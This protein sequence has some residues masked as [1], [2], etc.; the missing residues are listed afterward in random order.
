MARNDGIDRTSVRNLAV[1]D[2][3]VGNTQQHNEREKDSYRNPDILPHRTEWNV[4]FKKPTASYT[5]LFAQMEAAGTISTRGLKPD[6]THYCELIFDV[7]SAYFDNHGGYEFAKQFYAD[8]YKAAVQ[9]AGGEQYILSAVMHADEINRAMT[10]ALGREVY[11]YHLHVVY[12]PVVEKQILW[13]KRCKDKALVGTVKE[14]VMQV[15][16]SK[17]WASKPLLDDAGKPVLQK[18]G[19]PVLKKSYSVLQDDFFNY[20]RTAGYTDVERGERGSTEE[21]LTVTQFKVQRE[22][23]RLGSLSAQIDQKEQHLTQT[24]KTLSKTEKELAAIQ[25]KAAVTKDAL[26]H[27]QDM[28]SLGKRTLL[29]NYSLTEDEL[30]ALKKQAAHG[31]VV[32]VENRQLKQQLAAAKRDCAEWQARYRDLRNDVQPY[33][34]ALRHAPKRVRN[35]FENLLSQK[36][37]RTASIPKDRHHEQNAEL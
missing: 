35:F 24:N 25:K 33:L 7:N 23:E 2:K 28:E 8:A 31:Y 16:R 36:P 21:H 6:A 22:Q 10:E 3:A 20:M 17:K 1:S 29:G 15:S 4:H 18:N 5:D 27:A 34:N 26:I 32:D 12:V 30:S 14:T 9:I 19:K 13:S 11:H 37:E